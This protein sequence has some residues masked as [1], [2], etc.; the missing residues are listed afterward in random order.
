MRSEHSCGEEERDWKINIFLRFVTKFLIL[1]FFFF[2]L[3]II[4][5]LFFSFMLVTTNKK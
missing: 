3:F 4:I 1:L 2:S 5:F